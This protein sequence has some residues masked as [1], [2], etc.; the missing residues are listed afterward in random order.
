MRSIVFLLKLLNE[1]F[2][3]MEDE[4]WPGHNVRL[5][6]GV[7]RVNV[8][9]GIGADKKG[10]WQSIVLE[11]SDYDRNAIE[12]FRDTVPLLEAAMSESKKG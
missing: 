7:L 4:G 6:D 1:R 11:E 10:I 2:P 12:V 9:L 8:F 5:I 3:C